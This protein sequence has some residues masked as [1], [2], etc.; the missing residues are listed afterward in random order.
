MKLIQKVYYVSRVLH[1]AET[2]YTGIEKLALAL[3]VAARRLR[4]YFQAHERL[5]P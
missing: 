3:V 2:R 5:H 4:P 1:D